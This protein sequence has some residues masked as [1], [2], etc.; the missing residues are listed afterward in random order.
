MAA[1]NVVYRGKK[2][3]DVLFATTSKDPDYQKIRRIARYLEKTGLTVCLPEDHDVGREKT[4]TLTENIKRTKCFVFPIGRYKLSEEQQFIQNHALATALKYKK[5]LLVPMLL[6]DQANI[7]D[8]FNQFNPL[9]GYDNSESGFRNIA[10]RLKRTIKS[11]DQTGKVNNAEIDEFLNQL[12]DIDKQYIMDELT[13]EGFRPSDKNMNGSHESEPREPGRFQSF[14][15]KL[16]K[17]IWS[18]LSP[19]INFLYP[20]Y[21][22]AS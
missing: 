15:T 5:D 18:L 21:L 16:C 1:R 4:T 14:L 10:D 13:H 2:Q 3:I 8:K 6:D 7:P 22:V 11:S 17:L 19:V 12:R 20:S 9:E